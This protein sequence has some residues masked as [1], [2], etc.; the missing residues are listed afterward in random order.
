MESMGEV[1]SACF[2]LSLGSGYARVSKNRIAVVLTEQ[3]ADRIHAATVS[4]AP[5][6][7][8][9]KIP[10]TRFRPAALPG[11]RLE[12]IVSVV[13]KPPVPETGKVWMRSFGIPVIVIGANG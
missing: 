5:G 1:L 7:D 2:A 4:M 12:I 10:W 8:S 9:V 11:E 3:E 6:S 13:P